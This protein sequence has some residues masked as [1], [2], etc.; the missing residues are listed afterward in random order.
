[1]FIYTK[2]N[3]S[4]NSPPP[5]D[6]DIGFRITWLQMGSRQLFGTIVERR[7]Y[8]II[9]T[10]GSMAPSLQFVKDKLFLLLQ[11]GL[12]A[13]QSY[14]CLTSICRHDIIY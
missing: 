7:L 14:F 2:L 9:D 3:C 1:M 8:L 10:S 11:V 13:Y 4:S 5:T 6:Y 12:P